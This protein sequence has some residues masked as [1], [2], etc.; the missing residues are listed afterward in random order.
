MRIALL[1]LMLVAPTALADQCAWIPRGQAEK[2]ISKLKGKNVIEW[3]EPCGEPKPAK[4]AAKKAS[5]VTARPVDDGKLG[6]VLVNEKPVDLAYL[7]VEWGNTYRN[8]AS[9]V[10]C[11]ATGVSKRLTW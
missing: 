8:V 2:A 4:T 7:F 9:L 3:C 6:E 11:P 1:V 5:V 10:G